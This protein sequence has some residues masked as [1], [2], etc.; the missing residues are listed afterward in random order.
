M[1]DL[2]TK[3]LLER[4]HDGDD[5]ALG[6]LCRRYQTRILANVRIRLGAG[7]RKKIESWDIVQEVLIDALRGVKQAD[8]KTEGAFIKYL[9]RIVE[10]KIRDEAA[11][12]HAQK[13]NSEKEVP[14]DQPRSDGSPF[15]LSSKL[16]DSGV[17]TPSQIL[18]LNEE[19]L[20][21][22]RAMDLLAERYGQLGE[23]YRSLIIA[24]KLEEQSYQE[25]AEEYGKSADAIR[26]K[27]VRAMAA[28]TE[29][30]LELEA[31]G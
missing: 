17:L 27:V 31:N 2:A 3:V 25:L 19:M 28:L 30:V 21:L 12:Q 4:A 14:L 8:F 16:K 18:S 7:L 6:E 5:N 13:R 11:R 9:N 22:E 15:P 20:M 10:N 23:E 29:I 24:V 26:M 1:K